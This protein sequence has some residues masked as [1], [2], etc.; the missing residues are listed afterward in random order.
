MRLTDGGLETSLIFH[1]GLDLPHFAAFPLAESADGR[2]ELRR[3]W[4]PYLQI[5]RDHG[6]GFVVGTVTWRANPDWG[7]LLGYD[8]SR[9]RAANVAAAELARELASDIDDAVVEG[10]VG[11][12]GDGYMVGDEMTPGQAQ[13]YHSE[14]LEALAAA[15]V[16]QVAAVTFTYPDEAIGFVRAAQEAGVPAIVSFTV[17]TDGRLP[18]GHGLR[19]AIESVDAA[20]VAAPQGF[21]INCAHPTH[22]AAALT[23]GEWLSRIIGLRANASTM[24]H[25]ELDAAEELDDGDPA[26]LAARHRELMGRLPNLQVL[27]GCCGTD[28][29]HVRAISAACGK[30]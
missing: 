16:D 14:Q 28:D 3:Y 15:G 21:M 9:L 27:G 11:P 8:L 12:R 4:E 19:E 17:E 22:F 13:R 26:D 24:S 25:A 1:Q 23:E 20:T 18:S 30:F 2:A 29:R 10:V 6:A 7:G 5:A